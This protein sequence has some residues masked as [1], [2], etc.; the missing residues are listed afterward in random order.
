MELADVRKLQQAHRTWAVQKHGMKVTAKR[1][2]D[3][4]YKHHF[5]EREEKIKKAL[6]THDSPRETICDTLR[7]VYKM[8]QNPNGDEWKSKIEIQLIKAMEQAK[9]M[10]S[11]L[12]EYSTKWDDWVTKD[13]GVSS[14][15]AL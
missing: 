13:E 7:N 12:S 1:I 5:P 3:K 8:V 9:S 6:T 15:P 11:K 4:V 2:W 14:R 10:N